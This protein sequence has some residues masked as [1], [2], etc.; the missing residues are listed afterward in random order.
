LRLDFAFAAAARA[1]EEQIYSNRP[2]QLPAAWD[3]E[4]IY[5]HYGGFSI[6]NLSQSI[7]G[8]F[9]IPVEYPLHDMVWG[10]ALDSQPVERVVLVLSDGLGYRLLQEMVQQDPLVYALVKRITAGNGPIPLTSTLPS[11]TAVALPTM[12][13]GT[14]PGQHGMIGTVLYLRQF[15][16]LVNMLTYAPLFGAQA[17]GSLEAWGKAARTF[18]PVPGLAERLHK[19]GVATHL[20]IAKELVGTGLS[21]VL[22]R[23]VQHRYATAGLGDSWGRIHDVLHQTRG[24]RCFVTMYLS[25]VDALSHMYGQ[26][27]SHVKREIRSQ[28]QSLSELLEDRS[29][30]DGKTLVIMVADHG[31]VE[32][33]LALDLDRNETMQG[34]REALHMTYACDASLSYLFIRADFR[35]RVKEVLKERFSEHLTYA[36][37]SKAVECGIFGPQADHPDLLSRLGDLLVIARSGVR[38]A[39]QVR[40]FNAKSWHGGLSEWEMLVPLMWRRI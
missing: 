2:I 1:V 5:P 10:G 18:A 21:T 35:E 29:A 33:R 37:P 34:L 40:P 22:H 20:I 27:S 6:A 24:Q 12:W 36:D 25:N 26:R 4:V 39:D 13:T 17:L 16:T 38:L 28:L 15:S 8:L 23:G 9:G 3:H 7:L 30:R 31:H 19:A 14:F 11:T 32:T